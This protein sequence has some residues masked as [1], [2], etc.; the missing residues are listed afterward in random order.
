MTDRPFLTTTE[1]KKRIEALD[2]TG[3]LRVKIHVLNGIATLTC[4]GLDYKMHSFAYR[5]FGT[6]Q[7]QYRLIEG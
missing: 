5:V 7:K 2:P 1:A 3:E 4:L 6:M